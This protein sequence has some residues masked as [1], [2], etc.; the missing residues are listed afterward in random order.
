MVK[1]NTYYKMSGREGIGSS[2]NGLTAK[3]KVG[4]FSFVQREHLGKQRD[5]ESMQW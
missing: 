3:K 1:S 4:I 2:H 5:Q